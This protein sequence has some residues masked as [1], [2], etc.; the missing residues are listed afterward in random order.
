MRNFFRELRQRK[1]F[2]VAAAYVVIAW[3]LLQVAATVL[4][5][6]DTPAWVL[7]AVTVL[8]ALGFPVAVLLAWAY[9]LTPQGV[10]KTDSGG[11]AVAVT[12]DG[13][14]ATSAPNHEPDVAIELPSGP[15]IAVVPFRNLSGDSSQ[16]L[17]ADALT[18]DIV[19]GLTRS[20][21]LFVLSAGAA[22]GLGPGEQDLAQTGQ[23]LGVSYLLSGTVQKVGETLR[24]SAQLTDVANKVQ[25]WSQKYDREL[26]AETLF[27]VQ[28]DIR[29]QIVATLSDLHG[30]IYATQ[31][32]R[33]VHRPTASLN[34]YECLSVALAYDRH[35]S[36]DYHL[37]ARESL[38]RAIE[39]DP[40]FDEAWSHLSWIYTDEQ[41]FGFNPLPNPMERA[42]TAARKAIEL[43][44]DNY[45]SHWLLSRVHYF[46][47]HRDLFLAE[48]QRALDLNSSDGTTLGLL[49]VYI[50]F[51][52]EWERG[53][54]MVHK[55]K[56]LNPNH[57]DYYYTA[58]GIEAFVKGDHAAALEQF[59]KANLPAWVPHQSFLIAAYSALE[60]TQ[61]AH[62][63]VAQLRQLLPDLA[64]D[65]AAA[66]LNMYFPFQPELVR[67]LV[68]A[69]ES[70]GLPAADA[71]V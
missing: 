50:A 41:I 42:L 31:S 13:V 29:E 25:M 15:S 38:E 1:V 18:S 7:K 32:K 68:G 20:S 3:L 45:H 70:A 6:F 60:R 65:S 19:T 55:A 58:F 61:E 10:V 46:M 14:R 71:P 22:A 67:E 69:L 11:E 37:R 9:E 34:A 27:A 21:H 35:L 49:G 48:A 33:N 63:Q 51:A 23:S 4:P 39:L 26:S 5:I 62:G 2:T 52:G 17:F 66:Q 47:G 8:L 16:D 64:L 12:E 54:D 44:P 57:P 36:P 40:N 43:N 53:M 56:L 30:V 59:H 24:V 28:D